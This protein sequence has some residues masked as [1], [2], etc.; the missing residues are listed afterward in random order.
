MVLTNRKGVPRLM[1]ERRNTIDPERSGRIRRYNGT[2]RL[3]AHQAKPICRNASRTAQRDNNAKTRN[4]AAKQM[5]TNRQLSLQHLLYSDRQ[6]SLTA[7]LQELLKV[8]QRADVATTGGDLPGRRDGA[9]VEATQ[10][11]PGPPALVNERLE[12]VHSGGANNND[13][14]NSVQPLLRV[15][16]ALGLQS[17]RA[18][19]ISKPTYR[20]STRYIGEKHGNIGGYSNLITIA[21]VSQ[22]NRKRQRVNLWCSARGRTLGRLDIVDVRNEIFSVKV[23]SATT[24]LVAAIPLAFVS[25]A[26]SL[27]LFHYWPPVRDPTFGAHFRKVTVK[28]KSEVDRFGEQDNKLLMRTIEPF[29]YYKACF[30]SARTH[31][32]GRP[33]DKFRLVSFNRDVIS[34]SDASVS[35]KMGDTMLLCAVNAEL[36]EPL[37]D[38]PDYGA[39]YVGIEPISPQLLSNGDGI[40]EAKI[41]LQDFV[42]SSL[43][44]DLESLCISKGLLCWVIY[45]DVTILSN[46]SGLIDACLTAIMATL[47]RL[48]LPVVQAKD[49]DEPLSLKNVQIGAEADRRPLQLNL[50]FPV[51]STFLFYNEE[52]I[53]DP[54]LEEVNLFKSKMTILIGSNN[55]LCGLYKFGGSAAVNSSTLAQCK[56]LA[57]QHREEV[58]KTLRDI[59][60]EVQ[61]DSLNN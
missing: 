42:A 1:G 55:I 39:V 32:D 23:I 2:K 56:V 48:T 25:I 28:R 57:I 50:P 49:C 10:N 16:A 46:D 60:E 31:G 38:L 41:V 30:M 6:V 29:E 14:R 7:N 4:N 33:L 24:L 54:T 58:L 45:I 19:I 8:S 36:S 53:C 52:I 61:P 21:C 12:P 9:T 26:S 22:G 18:G 44:I 3:F 47:E 13:G 40:E 17:G 37:T 35:L 11:I 20:E 43:V 59:D 15:R 51:A 27:A 34:T 5:L